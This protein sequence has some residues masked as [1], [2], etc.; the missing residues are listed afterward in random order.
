MNRR[1]QKIT[2][3]FILLSILLIGVV[4][5]I[6]QAN[7]QINGTAK[8]QANTWD[9]HFDNI[10]VN[11]NSV[12][13]GEND[14][15]ATIDSENNCKVDFEVTLSIPGDFYE[16]TIDVVNAGT[17]DGMIGELNKTLKVNNETVSEVP[18]YLDY[19]VTYA[20]GMEILE[21]H[22]LS[23]GVTETYK[24]RLE[25]KTDIEEL[26]EAATIT[27]SLEPQ[28]LQA[29][30]SSIYRVDANFATDSWDEIIATYTTGNLTKLYQAM[31]EGTKKEVQLDMDYDGTPETTAHVRIANL[32]I[33][34]ECSSNGFSQSAC[35]FV[36]EFSDRIA[37]HQM[38]LTSTNVGGWPASEMRTYVNTDIYN[39]LPADLKSKII[40]TTI[41]SGH[42]STAGETNF[43]STDKIFLFSTKEVYGKAGT[44]NVVEN[45]TAEAETRQLDYFSF[46]K[47]TTSNYSLLIKRNLSNQTTSWWLRSALSNSNN[48]FYHVNSAGGWSEISGYSGYGVSPAFRIA[49]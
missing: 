14:S 11:E 42:G 47:V 10:Q 28:Y 18:D 40:E 44:S 12:S 8:I 21:N 45:D 15:A 16:F 17:I 25:F 43:T 26:P 4:Y 32:S 34:T 39:A 23:A 20:D 31:E 48:K 13:I 22:K 7:L 46:K 41:V 29:D 9:I 49:E 27:T 3:Q 1:K 33:P 19:S 36:I 38:N 30:S 2:T 24:V 5:A 35:G 6:L 37:I